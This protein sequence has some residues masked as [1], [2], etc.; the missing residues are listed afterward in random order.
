MQI[1]LAFGVLG[2]A[3]FIIIILIILAIA[4]IVFLIVYGVLR[5]K[6]KAENKK[7]SV[8]PLVVGILCLLPPI[9]VIVFA[10]GRISFIS[11]QNASF[12]NFREK[13]QYSS[14][15][16]T[17]TS[18]QREAVEGFFEIADKGDKEAIKALFTEEIQQSGKLDAQIDEFFEVYKGGFSGLDFDFTGGMSNGMDPAYISKNAEVVKDG[19]KYYVHISACYENSEN[20]EKVGLEYISLKSE[21]AYVTECDNDFSANNKYRYLYASV[22]N[23]EDFEIREIGYHKFQYKQ[24]DRQLTIQQVQEAVD[25]SFYMKHLIEKIGEPNASCKRYGEAIYELAEGESSKYALVKYS[26]LESIEKVSFIDE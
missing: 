13:W 9:A 4:G 6:R 24:F 25:N 16:I 8:I 15:W 2:V 19:V 20:L 17:D 11:F 18:A 5:S 22:V 3:A 23:D 10:I 12:E 21:Q 1:A 14:S 7:A 26:E